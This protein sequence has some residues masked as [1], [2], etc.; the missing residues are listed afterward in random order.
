[1]FS[2]CSNIVGLKQPNHLQRIPHSLYT[3]TQWVRVPL[4][5]SFRFVISFLLTFYHSFDMISSTDIRTWEPINSGNRINANQIPMASKQPTREP[6]PTIWYTKYIHL[7]KGSSSRRSKS[8]LLYF[9]SSYFYFYIYF[10][11]C[12]YI[13]ICIYICL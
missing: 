6:T 11:I 3:A 5:S 7:R 9:Q 8:L 4:Y 10:Y 1:M 12:G 13:Y 2:V